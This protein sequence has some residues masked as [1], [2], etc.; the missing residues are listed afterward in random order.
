MSDVV[1]ILMHAHNY[2]LNPSS[3]E[4]EARKIGGQECPAL[5]YF[6]SK[7]WCTLD[8]VFDQVTGGEEWTENDLLLKALGF[9]CIWDFMMWAYDPS[10]TLEDV[11]TTLEEAID[12][13]F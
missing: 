13:S 7:P 1:V 8:D 12:A 4:I 3:C 9:A 2:L 10:L 5:D 11:I 6:F